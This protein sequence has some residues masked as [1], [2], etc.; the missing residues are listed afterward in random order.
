MP[1]ALICYF[2]LTGRTK[3]AA[4]ALAAELSHFSITIEPIVYL[5]KKFLKDQQRLMQGDATMLQMSTTI[6]DLSPYDLIC[7][8]MP[9]HGGRPSFALDAYLKK[10][11]GLEGKKV[12]IFATCRFLL[13]Q[14]PTIMRVAI[15]QQGGNIIGEIWLK[16]FFTLKVEPI[17]K[18]AGKLNSI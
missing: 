11:K 18:Y 12:F 1:K 13:Y 7:I 8:G 9:V 14:T 17:K 15:E 2:S 5:G 6:L 16:N 4:E 3:R 10:V